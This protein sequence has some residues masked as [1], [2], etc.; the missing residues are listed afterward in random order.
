MQQPPAI[1]PKNTDIAPNSTAPFFMTIGLACDH[2]GYFYKEALKAHLE[3]RGHTIV[4]FGTNSDASCDYPDFVHSLGDAIDK[5]ILTWGMAICGSG[6][7]VCITANKHQYVR[8]ALVWNADIAALSRQHNN[9][10]V[11][12]LPSRF[13]S[14][15]AAKEYADLFFATEFEGGRHQFR[16]DKIALD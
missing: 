7:G 10:N 15:E 6:Q 16:V 11:V 2:A 3:Q 9:A 12:C 14:L 5:G 4:D 1:S 8:A 13:I